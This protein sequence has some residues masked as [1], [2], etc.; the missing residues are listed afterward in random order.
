[1][2]SKGQVTPRRINQPSIEHE[3][4]EEIRRRCDAVCA[5]E[6]KVKAFDSV[7]DLS[8]FSNLLIP[9]STSMEQDQ[10]NFFRNEAELP[11]ISSSFIRMLIGG[12]LRKAPEVVLPEYLPEEA[13][14]HI[15]NEIGKDSSSLTSLLDE[16]LYNEIITD[17]AWIYVEHPVS[18]TEDTSLWP[19]PVLWKGEDVIN[20]RVDTGKDGIQKLSM[21]AYRDYEEVYPKEI[22]LQT[23]EIHSSFYSVVWLHF[24]EDG[25]Y[26][27]AKYRAST[28]S[29][30]KEIIDTTNT[31]SSFDFIEEY[32]APEIGG[33]ALNYIPA[34]PLNGSY[35][36]KEPIILTLV[37]REVHLY[38]KMAR[39]NHLLYNAATYTPV[40][41]SA[42]EP[43]DFA[44][45][46][47]SGLGTWLQIGV[48]DE[49]EALQIPTEALEHLEKS[50]AANIEEMAKLGVRMLSPEKAQ[51]GVALTLRNASQSSQIG[52]LSLKV[53]NT[54][55]Q[56]IAFM[57]SWKYQKEVSTAEV[58]IKL[59]TDFMQSYTGD[60]WVEMATEWYQE[61]LIPRSLWLTICKANDAVPPE[62]DDDLGKLEMNNDPLKLAQEEM[63]KDP[64]QSF[65]G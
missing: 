31:S 17:N 34:W 52:T 65:K 44:K 22:D 1:M 18:D 55:R 38:N 6:Q 54:F 12:L 46:V 50:I 8:R 11:G 5:G 26:R 51:S 40:L 14:Q 49:I 16:A 23:P 61:M 24:I 36:V 56:V 27:I 35:T 3:S 37:N 62:Y 58:S 42:M 10:Y 47:G 60:N 2:S 30:Y 28:G 48:D 29:Q 4:Q 7:L 21:I 53:A 19:T 32:S 25:K 45:L 20:T 13:Q 41:K 39:R 33:E 64:A 43:S 63:N 57:L 9:F 59:S 15:S